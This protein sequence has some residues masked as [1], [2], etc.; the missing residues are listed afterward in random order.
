MGIKITTWNIE[1][2]QN[3]ISQN[4]TQTTVNRRQRVRQ[5]I[6]QIDP[7]ILCMQEGPKGEQAVTDFSAQVLENRW[8]PVMLR[9]PGEP[10]GLRD[11]EYQIKGNQ[12]IWF[13]V[14]A[15]LEPRGELQPPAIWQAFNGM[16]NWPVNLWGEEKAV[17]HGHYRHPQVLSFDLGRDKKLELIGVHLKSKINQKPIVRDMEGN[18]VGDY[19]DEALQARIQLATEAR[20]VRQY[21]AA[22]FEQLAHPA[23]VVLG[24]CNDGPGHDFFETLYLYF[25][26]IS[27]LQGDV[28]LAERFFNHAL[29]DY[30]ARLRW[31]AKYRDE[32]L[33]VPASQN[34]LLLDHI[35]ISQPLCRGELPVV[36]HAHAGQVEHEAF[37]MGNAGS[38]SA[39]RTSDHRPVSCQLDDN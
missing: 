22:R 8:A 28:M 39:T 15:G 34:P 17:S 3:L 37:A 10:L 29:F 4:P 26:L 32:V 35:L 20:N 27:N 25:D 18:L 38:T 11:R 19:V 9:R 2:A 30:P 24:D 13:L 23:I 1:H 6:E 16:K 33:G 5:T 7:D 31:T 14:R 12:W 36:A 21:I